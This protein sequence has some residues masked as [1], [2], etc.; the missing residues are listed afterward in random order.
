MV[1]VYNHSRFEE[2]LELLLTSV[3][4]DRRQLI[5]TARWFAQLL[6][7]MRKW[8][9][10]FISC[11]RAHPA[12]D[13]YGGRDTRELLQDIQH[14]EAQWGHSSQRDVS[15]GSMRDRMYALAETMFEEL[16]WVPEHVRFDLRLSMMSWD[17]PS[18][19]R[20]L[21]RAEPRGVMYAIAD[22]IE[23]CRAVEVGI[24]AKA[25]E[26]GIEF[27]SIEEY[28]RALTRDS[29]PIVDLSKKQAIVGSAASAGAPEGRRAS[30]RSS[31]PTQLEWLADIKA[32]QDAI[33]PKSVAP[34]IAEALR[35]DILA[36][37]AD[38]LF[39][40]S[41]AERAL[42]LDRLSLV[43]SSA[44]R[45]FLHDCKHIQVDVLA[46][47]TASALVAARLRS[48]A[49]VSRFCR[50]W[51]N[52]LLPD[53]S[54]WV[55]SFQGS[56]TA[57]AIMRGVFP[58][59][60]SRTPTQFRRDVDAAREIVESRPQDL[61]R[62]DPRLVTAAISFLANIGSTCSPDVEPAAIQHVQ[63]SMQ[64]AWMSAVTESG[65][66]SGCKDVFLLLPSKCG[67]VELLANGPAS[68]PLIRAAFKICPDERFRFSR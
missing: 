53:D 61:N 59:R 14:R 7:E 45:S 40:T 67:F 44:L 35:D 63:A 57:G 8:N 56:A 50:L 22:Y 66:E 42:S 49:I 68:G 46:T 3:P 30:S 13:V 10:G 28:E 2:S 36:P 38:S 60:P 9:S 17:A 64:R 31:T 65:R 24:Q 26:F 1:F 51:L 29:D 41:D 37:A 48:H 6:H 55:V 58:R 19:W 27:L 20:D 23:S 12:F 11:L 15:S 16:D 25:K 62:I 34:A 33:S 47:E 52:T 5:R 18:L 32:A 39:T 4:M 21:S 54:P 43:V